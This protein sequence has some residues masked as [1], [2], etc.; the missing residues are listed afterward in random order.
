MKPTLVPIEAPWPLSAYDVV[1]P[2]SGLVLGVVRQV[3]METIRM[4]NRGGATY[5]KIKRWEGTKSG[6]GPKYTPSRKTALE[7]VLR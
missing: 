6:V 1:H 2:E 4:N 5:R 7:W 3:W